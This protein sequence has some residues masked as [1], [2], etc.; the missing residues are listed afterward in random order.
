MTAFQKDMAQVIEKVGIINDGTL[1]FVMPGFK[2]DTSVEELDLSTR[3]KNALFRGGIKTLGQ[4]CEHNV[5]KLRGV[6]KNCIRNINTKM[7]SHYYSGLNESQRE[8]FWAKTIKA[9]L[10]KAEG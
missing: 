10:E 3:S 5:S 8:E 1:V 7:M 9:T 6:G 4:I 2:A